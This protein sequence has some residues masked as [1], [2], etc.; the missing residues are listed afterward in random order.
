M[1]RGLKIR[2]KDLN[3]ALQR[4]NLVEK[5]LQLRVWAFEHEWP[6]TIV[7]AGNQACGE[8]WVEVTHLACA[9]CDIPPRCTVHHNFPVSKDASDV[10]RHIRAKYKDVRYKPA[11]NGTPDVKPKKKRAKR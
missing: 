1:M 5:E 10:L 7:F 9:A 4:V 8:Y 11:I 2:C 3:D 6:A